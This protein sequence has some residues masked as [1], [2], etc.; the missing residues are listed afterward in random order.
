MI[1]STCGTPGKPKKVSRGSLLIEIILW[2][3]FLVPGIL[4]SLWRMGSK[5]KVCRK[6]GSPSMVPVNS[7]VGRKLQAQS[8]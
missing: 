1:C 7:P 3:C 2:C 8:V 5:Q 6:C 4:Y